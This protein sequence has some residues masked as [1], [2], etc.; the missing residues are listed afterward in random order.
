MEGP[1]LHSQTSLAHRPKQHHSYSLFP[2]ESRGKMSSLPFLLASPSAM[3]TSR[4]ATSTPIPA[5]STR[6]CA[7]PP[8]WGTP[9]FVARRRRFMVSLAA[10]GG[11]HR[12][13]EQTMGSADRKGGSFREVGDGELATL[14]RQL[15]RKGMPDAAAQLFHDARAKVCE[16][17]AR[18]AMSAL[19]LCYAD[20]GLFQESRAL[21]VDIINSSFVPAMEVVL[22]L[23]DTY[24]SAGQFDEV[25]RVVHEVTA[26]E[27]EFCAEVYSSAVSCFG[28]AGRLEMMEATVQEMGS[29][30]VKIDSLT[31]N[32]F[33]KYYSMFGSLPEMEIAYERLKRSRILIEE[34]AIRSM[35]RAYITRRKFYQLG[36][37]LRD[38]GLGRRNLGNL[39]WN[40]LL[41][42]YAANFKMK[43]L[44]REFL[45]MVEAGFSPDLTTFNVRA[46]AFSRMCMFWDL[47][48]SVEHM[49]HKRVTPD[50]VTYGCL[51][52]MYLERRLGRNLSFVLDKMDVHSHPRVSTDPLVFEA[53]GKGDFHA[54]SEAL[55]ESN[56]H[57]RWTYSK[58]ISIYVK[59]QYRSNQIF[60]NY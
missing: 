60:W 49:N 33:V 51:V 14:I 26:R 34:E 16:D 20:N 47:H 46:L 8:R 5:S 12:E 19:M 57:R 11:R 2:S 29:K 7:P 56:S 22:R 32:S 52:D 27:Y 25:A 30:G 41:L 4:S 48:L 39:L 28:K 23:M 50:L 15:G 55:L 43:S 24:G 3:E 54:S 1:Y 42:S 31:G 44:Q 6:W 10:R 18:A 38:V 59:K 17:A 35:A 36:E 45:G 21:W 13:P 40:L 53:L 9:V 58:L 37:F